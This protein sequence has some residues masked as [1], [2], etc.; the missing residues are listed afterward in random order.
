MQLDETEAIVSEH[1]HASFERQSV[2]NSDRLET[3]ESP[4]EKVAPETESVYKDQEHKGT[5]DCA[6]SIPDRSDTEG[7]EFHLVARIPPL[8]RNTSEAGIAEPQTG[9]LEENNLDQSAT[10]LE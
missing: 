7:V 2:H 4:R 10:E 1:W 8:E 6:G 9:Y 3:S 5:N